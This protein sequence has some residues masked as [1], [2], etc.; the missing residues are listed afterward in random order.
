MKGVAQKPLQNLSGLFLLLRNFPHIN[1]TGNAGTFWKSPSTETPNAVVE[2]RQKSAGKKKTLD[3]RP[4]LL[5][6]P[7][8]NTTTATLG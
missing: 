8:A 7:K 2:R 6:S 4:L 3:E 1:W 5:R